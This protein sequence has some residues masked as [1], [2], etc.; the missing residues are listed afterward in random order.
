MQAVTFVLTI[1]F[2][3][4]M[5][6]HLEKIAVQIDEG[7]LTPSDY[8]VLVERIPTGVHQ[9]DLRKDIKYI[10]ENEIVPGRK[11]HIADI[12]FIYKLSRFN[13]AYKK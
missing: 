3:V 13:E 7:N 2:A 1:S 5:S 12:I 8:A 11:L 9:E 6:F 10:F 4:F